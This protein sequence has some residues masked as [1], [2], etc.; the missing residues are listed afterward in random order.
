MRILLLFALATSVSAR[1]AAQ[2]IETPQ[3]FDSAHRVMA[4]TPALAERLHLASPLWPASVPYR[5]VRLYSVEPGG[6]YVLVVVRP[7]GALERYAL[8]DAQRAT[9]GAAIDAASATAGHPGGEISADIVSEP[10]GNAFARTQAVLGTTVYGPIAASLAED[11]RA[12]TGL[13][14]LVA[15]GTFF[16]SYGAAQQEPFTRAQSDLA[17]GLGL[18]SATGGW[19]AG[20]AATGGSETG[21]RVASLASAVAG[22]IAGANLGRNLSD[23][24]AHSGMLGLDM[25]AVAALDASAVLGLS[26]RATAAA[27]TAGGLVG[28]PLG[29]RYP[30]GVSY[31]V[32]AGDAQSVGTSGLIGAMIGGAIG[33]HEHASAHQVEFSLASGYLAGA[34]VGESALARQFDLTQSQANILKVGAVAGALMGA[35]IPALANSGN[36]QFV[37]G[38]AGAG[39]TLAVAGLA[40]SFPSRAGDSGSG[41]PSRRFRSLNR[42]SI[43]LPA[44]SIVRL[45]AHSPGAHPLVHIAF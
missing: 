23:A 26:G 27:A 42:F 37:L 16:I 32:T 14:L 4:V 3:P 11:G 30:R 35:A 39:A 21:V 31:N 1:A 10:A 33:A 29:F 36:V 45:A 28:L 2:T 40:S 34:L 25:G 41:Q 19:L 9:L 17:A 24:E 5:E 8:T 12:A 7:S 18:A 20:Y 13:Y 22:T 43:D 15:G 44:A 38:S 6:G